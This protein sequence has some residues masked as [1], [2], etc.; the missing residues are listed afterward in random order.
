MKEKMEGLPLDVSS[1]GDEGAQMITL[2]ET[3][4]LEE[5]EE[6][7]QPPNVHILTA[8]HV[9]DQSDCGASVG[10]T[11]I[12]DLVFADDAVI[13]AE[14]LEVLVMALEV[15]HEE[16]KPLGLEVSW[17]KTKVQLERGTEQVGH[18]DR[19]HP[20]SLS[21][22]LQDHGEELSRLHRD[23]TLSS[24]HCLVC[25]AKLGVS[26]RGAMEVFSEKA[27]TSHRQLQVHVVL[28]T[29]VN[30][31]VSA[32]VAH[33]SIVCKK[34]FKLIDD[35][36]SLEGQLINMKQVVTNKYMRTL[37]LVKEDSVVAPEGGDNSVLEEDSLN[38][39]ATSLTKDDKDFK[40]YMGAGGP[41]GKPRRGRRARS[42]GRTP[43]VKLEVKQE[44][45]VEV[46]TGLAA[47]DNVEAFKHQASGGGRGGSS[48]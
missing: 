9:V 4:A 6:E 2:V 20:H 24:P 22:H 34:C 35:I 40:V 30:Q 25:N 29:I 48:P 43:S 39:E 12:T 32:V 27:K 1:L 5:E 19:H 28:G 11:K 42:R 36:D 26:A 7:T 14:S 16:A 45:A 15:L 8:H 18:E 37:A 38:L 46:I 3:S 47:S 21:H 10:N 23:V 33:S 31:D 17:L 44:E 41:G 13:F